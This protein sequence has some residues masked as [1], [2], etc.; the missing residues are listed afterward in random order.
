MERLVRLCYKQGGYQFAKKPSDIA[1]EYGIDRIA[2]LAS[3]ENPAPPSP[4]VIAAAEAALHDVN[5]YPDERV[6]LL[7]TALRKYYG[8]YPFV[9]GVG[10]D[11]VIETLIRTLVEPGETVAISTPTFSFYRLAALAQGGKIV[12]VPREKDFSVDPAALVLAAK[13]AKITVLCSPNNPTGNATPVD[14]VAEVLEGIDGILFLDNAYVEF[15]DFDY[16]PLV[17]K[18]GN[19][20][21]G[22]TFSK[23]HALAGLRIGYAFVP[24]WL[25]PFYLRAGTPFT[26]N[27]VSCAA[28]A[29]ALADKERAARYIAQVKM[30][31]KRY[32]EEVKYPVLPSDANFVMVDVAPHA[33]DEMVEKLARRGVIVRSC[34]SF[35]GLPDHYIRVSVGDDW[36]NELFKR[37]INLL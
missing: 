2:R 16:L 37:E 5:R 25:Q 10:M 35:T 23:V 6:D 22:R 27:S 12:T 28:A 21:I 9:T 4:A 36:E 20:V 30:W 24:S 15:S 3:N 1:R 17:K 19:L 33:G 14:D 13:T 8:D 34:G 29:A 11:G 26:V 32:R 18:Y 31:R 7:T